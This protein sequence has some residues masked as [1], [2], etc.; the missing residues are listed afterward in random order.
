MDD[1]CDCHMR[2]LRACDSVTCKMIEELLAQIHSGWAALYVLGALFF[3]CLIRKA[4]VSMEI[5]TLG[6]RAPRIR[7]YLP[8]GR[9][10]PTVKKL[11][12]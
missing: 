9:S 2:Y 3:A 5:S 6:Y 10:S 12:G 8:W 11:T 4:Q 7:F 1:L